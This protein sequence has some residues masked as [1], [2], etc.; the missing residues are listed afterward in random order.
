MVAFVGLEIWKDVNSHLSR[1]IEA[2]LTEE[3]QSDE[4]SHD[5]ERLISALQ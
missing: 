4:L 5:G 1:A 2:L 3:L